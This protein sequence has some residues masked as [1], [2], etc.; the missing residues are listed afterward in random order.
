MRE[1][2]AHHAI[3]P[4]NDVTIIGLGPR[5]PQIL[6]LLADG[7]LDGAI[8]S[9]PHVTIGEQAGLFNVWL[10]LNSLDFVPRMQWS[11][12]VANDNVLAQ[13][14]NLVAA[15]LRGCRRSYRYAAQNRAE[16]ADFGARYFGIEHDTMTKSIDR[17]F[18]DLHFDCEI[19]LEGMGAAIALQQKLGAMTLPIRLADIVDARFSPCVF[20]DRTDAPKDPASAQASGQG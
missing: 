10:G 19:D 3:D 4:D 16:W 18:K 2:L 17:E 12:M 6:R 15:V 11:I 8:I 7:E 13:E 14:P 1:V 20:S 5:Y 9:E